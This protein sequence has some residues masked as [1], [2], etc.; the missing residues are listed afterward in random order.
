VL[1]DFFD[2]L[3]DRFD[4]LYGDPFGFVLCT[5]CFFCFFCFVLVLKFSQICFVEDPFGFDV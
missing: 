5:T 4:V 2:V 1:W 3:D